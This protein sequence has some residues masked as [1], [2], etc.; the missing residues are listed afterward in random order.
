MVRDLIHKFLKI[1]NILPSSII[2]ANECHDKSFSD[3]ELLREWT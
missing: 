2:K 1:G 3:F